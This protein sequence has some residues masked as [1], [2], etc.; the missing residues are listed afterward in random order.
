M[1]LRINPTSLTFLNPMIAPLS[2]V[3]IVSGT[4]DSFFLRAIGRENLALGEINMYYHNLRIKLFKN[5]ELD[6]STFL[7][8]AA[9]F[10]ANSFL[11]RKNNNGK[12]GIVYFERLEDRSFFNYIVKMT[13]SGMASSIGIK[14]NKK[15]LKKY[16]REV[17]I[18]SLLPITGF[19][20]K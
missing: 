6:Q 1:T 11:I 10:I 9:S 12:P 5:A 20:F 16:K 18:K 19:D 17:H 4:V 7:T 8:K 2:N 15:Y 13:F 3:K 14:S